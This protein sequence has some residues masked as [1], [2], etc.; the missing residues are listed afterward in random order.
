MKAFHF[1]HQTQTAGT[2][3]LQLIPPMADLIAR[4]TSLV[5]TAGTTAHDLIF[6]RARGQVKTT[7][8]S[9]ASATTITVD[10]TSFSGETIAANDYLVVEH[11]DGT[12]GA[13][14][15]SSVA[16]LVVTINALAKA[17]N[18]GAKVFVMG[19]P[20]DA[21]HSTLKSIASTRIEFAD[22]VSGI[23]QG[24]FED[25]TAYA[26]TGRGDPVLIYTTNATNAGTLNRGAA[27]YVTG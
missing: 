3:I 21:A 20:G 12:Y 15:V 24:G 14:L 18:A 5:Y 27:S 2:V 23:A 19:A 22:Y 7:A 4:L 9:A 1:F 26:R 8:A 25:G 16:A 13:Y 6:M 10:S 17:V 11:G